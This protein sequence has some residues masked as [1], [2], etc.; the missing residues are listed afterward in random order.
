MTLSVCCMTSDPMPRVAAILGLLRSTADEIVVA[1]DSRVEEVELA[2]LGGVADRLFRFDFEPPVDRPRAWLAGQCAGDYILWIDGDELPSRALVRALPELCSAGGAQTIITRRWLFP[3]A[4]HWLDEFPWWPDLQIRLCRNDE[5]TMWFGPTHEPLGL[6][7][8]V[9]YLDAPLYHL[10]CVV[11]S[12]GARRSKARRYDEERPGLTSPAGGP[13]NEV[14]LVPERYATVR[15]APVPAEDRLWI[16][17][18]LGASAAAASRTVPEVAMA[19]SEEID[20]AAPTRSFRPE[21]YSARIDVVERD[22]RMEAA[23]NRPILVRV[24]NDGVETWPWQEH[25]PIRINVGYHWR[26][27]DGSML[28]Q[29]GLRTPMPHIVHPGESLLILVTVA[30]P[31]QPGPY[32]LELDL[33]HENVRWFECSTT[34]DVLVAPRWRRHDPALS[35]GRPARRSN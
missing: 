31:A 12:L 19:P 14:L 30:A 7:P 16:D 29:G 23:Q 35:T 25:H 33:V 5:A 3:D 34:A 20:A 1:V 22:L 15:P 17:E 21:A 8:P 26:S 11:S 32:L 4:G 10:S 18:V 13:F 6:T 9:R 27:P 28:A 24:H 2:P